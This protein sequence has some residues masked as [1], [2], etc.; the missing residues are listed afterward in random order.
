[1][2]DVDTILGRLEKLDDERQDLQQQ[3]QRMQAAQIMEEA[4]ANDLTTGVRM[5]MGPGAPRFSTRSF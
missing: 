3:L 2:N 1:M 4:G 5:S